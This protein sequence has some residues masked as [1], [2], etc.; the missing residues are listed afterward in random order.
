MKYLAILLAVLL[1]GSAAANVSQPANAVPQEYLLVIESPQEE[2]AKE[3]PQSTV[4]LQLKTDG[5]VCTLELEEYLVG[6]VLSEMLPSFAEETFKAQAVAARTFAIRMMYGGKHDDCSL[7]SNASCCQA[8]NSRQT[9]KTKLGARFDE[10]WEKAQK[11]V[12]ETQGEVLLY[13]GKLI[14]AVYF[15]CSGGTSEPAVAVWGTDV[16]Y[17]Q[18]VQSPG[19]ESSGKYASEVRVPFQEFRSRLSRHNAEVWFAVM[20][21][22]WLGEVRRSAGGGVESMELG[23]VKFSGTQLRKIFGLASTLFDVAIGNGEVIF[24]VRGYG[25]R[26]GMSQYGADA[27]AR[28]GKTYREILCHYYTGVSIKKLSQTKLG[29]FVFT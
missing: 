11:A 5:G 14:E 7:C 21:Q 24:S 10:Y 29:Q 15:S 17:L 9:L 4:T 3:E 28:Q 27:M 18:S 16:P 8:W 19:E 13:D 2:S 20:P 25:H 1:C 26:V 12:R 6:V 22:D 23:G